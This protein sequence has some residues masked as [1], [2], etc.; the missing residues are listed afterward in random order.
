MML[1]LGFITLVMMLVMLWVVGELLIGYTMG[2][3]GAFDWLYYG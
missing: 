1:K 3:R 2:S